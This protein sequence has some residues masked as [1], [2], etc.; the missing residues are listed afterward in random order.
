M[1]R[2]GV[3]HAHFQEFYM[4]FLQGR[5]KTTHIP[6]SPYASALS[7]RSFFKLSGA[8]L[9]GA[10]VPGF[11]SSC[12]VKDPHVL[13]RLEKPAGDVT[14]C[15]VRSQ[16][17]AAAV[18]RAI[19][20][21]GGLDDIQPGDTVLIK[22]NMTACIP[23]ANGRITTHP[24]VVRAVIRAVKAKTDAAA[25]TVADASGFSYS[26]MEA[27]VSGGIYAIAQAE[28]V[29]LVTWEKGAY[30]Y[31][32]S[33]DF[34]HIKRALEVPADLYGFDHFINVPMLKDHSTQNAQFTCCLKNHVGVIRPRSRMLDNAGGLHAADCA[35]K[36][37]E[38]NLVVPR[39][40]MDIVDALSVVLKGGPAASDMII[41][42]AGLVL[43]SKDRVACDSVAVAVLKYYAEGQGIDMPYVGT[44]V[45]EQAQI[46][47]ALELNLGRPAEQIQILHD[48]VDDIA[49]IREQWV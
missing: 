44:S 29:R 36:I 18:N 49:G 13:P 35:Q 39:H 9:A 5:S 19:D 42:D 23:S 28:G 25:I 46:K 22:P 27:A 15:V 26:P 34:Q 40:T 48:G 21:A 12:A 20:L 1:R 41:H 6:A 47:R 45:W 24:E 3:C 37:A 8:A 7:R 31:V 10:A 33:P 14:V 30:I 4:A 43:A 38:M 16:D 11:L 2:I 17:S 32:I